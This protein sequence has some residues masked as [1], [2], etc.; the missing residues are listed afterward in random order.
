MGGTSS[1][2]E[3]PIIF[4]ARSR[5]L[6]GTF[7]S[8]PMTSTSLRASVRLLAK[9]LL[10]A[11]VWDR[12]RHSAQ[13]RRN[14]IY[15]QQSL[16]EIDVEGFS[17][18]IPENHILRQLRVQQPLRDKCVKVLAHHVFRRYPEGAA[19]DVGAN[20]GDTAAMM[21]SAAGNPLVLVEASDYFFTLLERNTKG[22]PN[23]V[24]LLQA[25]VGNGQPAQGLLEHW[26]GTA[27]FV[28]SDGAHDSVPTV[29][30]KDFAPDATRLIKIDTDGFDY[31]I[32]KHSRE[33]LHAKA[34]V[35][36]YENETKTPA[37]LRTSEETLAM[38]DAVGY[39][40]FILWDDA[41][42][43]VGGFDATESVVDIIRC[44]H[45]NAR[46]SRSR[47]IHGLDIAAFSAADGSLATTVLQ[48]YREL[49]AA[50]LLPESM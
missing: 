28:E 25:L 21:A 40:H 7:P 23:S 12:L 32:L 30:L 19:I 9:R 22:L 24:T 6:A 10:P 43:L 50:T 17:L 2:L 4:F 49:M 26:G 45:A 35:V 34:P 27:R 14:G 42:H 20:I 16:R 31:E 1:L 29:Q 44:L 5:L 15:F 33:F 36:L 18:L 39:R 3:I 41:G 38:L 48:H 47:N 46:L 11:S 13:T 8:E 37:A